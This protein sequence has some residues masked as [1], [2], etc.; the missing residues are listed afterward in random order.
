MIESVRR[1]TGKRSGVSD[2]ITKKERPDEGAPFFAKR[3][4]LLLIL[5]LEA[6]F[7]IVDP[8]RAQVPGE[9]PR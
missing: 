4:Q 7:E 6:L 5:E 8:I 1:G 2:T 9:T 3:A